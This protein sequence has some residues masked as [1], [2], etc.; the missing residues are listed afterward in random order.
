MD[1]IQGTYFDGKSSKPHSV[2]V[3]LDYKFIVFKGI[4]NPDISEHWALKEIK[5]LDF[6]ASNELH[7][8]F[9]EKPQKSLIIEGKDELQ[10]FKKNYPELFHKN[11]YFK[12]LKGNPL[13]VFFISLILLII[14]TSFYFFIVAPFVADRVAS[15]IPQEQEIVL[16][17]KMFESMEEYL[18]IDEDKSKILNNFYQNL[19]FHDT[20]PVELYY[21]DTKEVNAFAIPGGKI[22]VFEGLIDKL[23]SWEELAGLIAHELAHVEKRHS[24]RNL[25]RNLST[26]F[27]VA[28]ITTDVSGITSVMIDN[29]FKLKDLSNSRSYEKEADNAG[30]DLM[31]QSDIDPNGI[32]ELL[33]ILDQYK[34]LKLKGTS[35]KILRILSTHPIT[36]D[37]IRYTEEKINNL[38]PHTYKE[39]NEANNIFNELK[40]AIEDKNKTT[41]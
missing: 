30:I 10:L 24:L 8:H 36:E 20:Y 21:S 33:K 16:G 3:D 9:G 39:N 4:E 13:K 12:I 1:S 23:D 27:I 35:K 32:L 28:V 40:N 7:L 17:D 38:T 5:N 14:I 31:V 18:D 29:A 41:Q 26:Y 11:I 34:T 37:R 22:V 19:H 25:S 6:S 2:K 15:I